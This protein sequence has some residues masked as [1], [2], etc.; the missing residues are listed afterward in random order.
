[1]PG[2]AKFLALTLATFGSSKTG[3]N[4]HPSVARLAREMEVT[5]R[6]VMRGMKWLRDNGWIVREKQ[7]NRWRSHADEYR[8]NVPEN[9]LDVMWLDPYS[10]PYSSVPPDTSVT[11]TSEVQLTLVSP[12]QGSASNVQVTSEQCLGDISASPGDK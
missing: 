2:S 7:G 5:E 8:L 1:M 11:Q 3:K 12:G 6:T 10:H 9:V 4:I